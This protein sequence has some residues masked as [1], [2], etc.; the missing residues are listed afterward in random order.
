MKQTWWVA[1]R[2]LRLSPQFLFWCLVLAGAPALAQQRYQSLAD[3]LQAGRNLSGAFGPASVN[4]INGGAQYS[5]IAGGG[6]VK[7][8]NPATGQEAELF[9]AA[10]LKFPDRDAPFAYQSF[11]F[12]QDSRY[13]LFQANFR[14]VWRFSGNSDYYVYSLADKSLQLAAKDARTAQLSP[15]GK[16][17]GYEREGNLFVYD[18]ATKQETQLTSDAQDELYNGRFGWA[19][20]EEFALAQA[21]VWSPDSKYLAFW[22]SDERGVPLFQMTDYAGKHP[23][24]DKLRYPKVGDPV[25][26]VRTG[27]IDIDKKQRQWL[28]IDLAGG[29]LPR[30]YWTSVPGQVAVVHLNRAQ[31]EMKLFFADALTGN[32]RLVLE[33][34]SNAWIDVYDFFAGMTHY[35]NFPQGVQEF[36]WISDRDG[37]SHLYRYDYTGKLL[38]QVTSGGFDVVTVPLVDPKKKLAYYVSTEKSP[39]ERH[40]Y[41]IGTDG[42]KKKQLT[43]TDGRHTIDLAPNGAYYLDR[44]SNTQTPTQVEL[45]GTDGKML[46]K[47]EDNAKVAEYIKLHTYAPRELVRFTTS[48]GQPLDAYLVKP[49]GFDENKKYPVLLN[50]YGGPG[51]QSVYNEF[52]RDTW[53]QWLAQEGYI[54]ASVNNR[55]S[56]GYGKKFKTVVFERLGEYESRDFVETMNYLKAQKWIDGD[57]LAIRGHSYGGY[58]AS[59]TML[60]HPGVFKVALVG[61]PVTD[62]RLYDCIYTERYM[63]LLPQNEEAYKKS[64]PTTH[65]SK[66]QGRMFIAHSTMDENVHVQNTF[67]LVK[68]L[69]DNG[70]DADLRIYPPGTHGVAYSAQSRLLLFGQ[71]TDYLNRY[72]KG[73]AE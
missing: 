33:E 21:W 53:E 16:K 69:I 54:V 58:M 52:G 32:A 22:Q 42:K 39:L 62:W 30:L 26:V 50:I 13:L 24:Y 17:V 51:S 15:D 46:K 12:S 45:W 57:N 43:K 3:A 18:L 71:Y 5:F 25:P 72:L 7:T 47:L 55:G 48:D 2:H 70:K 64:S 29:Y 28:N 19:Y 63:G 49:I 27:V 56:G 60:T 20:E 4:W 41:V 23:H 35:F 6:L 14:P 37:H 1:Q 65:A 9:S 59:Y 61:A 34:K 11:Q 44:Y 68:A 10:G 66:L 8:H 67:Q 40:L 36:Y 73:K 38:G 31:T